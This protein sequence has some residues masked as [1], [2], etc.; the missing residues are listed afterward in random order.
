MNPDRLNDEF[1]FQLSA[2]GIAY[3][4]E[5]RAVPERRFR[6]DFALPDVRVLVEVQGGIWMRER[7]GHTSG[8]GVRRDCEKA[9]LAALHGWRTLFFTP[10]MVRSGEAI[11]MI[12]RI[13]R[14]TL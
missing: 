12:E 4:R 7:T 13:I 3:E 9:N 6:W 1:A 2:Y 10:D 14:Q 5:Y 11:A 8:R